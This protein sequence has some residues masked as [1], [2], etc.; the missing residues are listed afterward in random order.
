[1]LEEALDPDR[2]DARP[3]AYG[4]PREVVLQAER[5]YTE[6]EGGEVEDRLRSLGYIE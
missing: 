3:P 1:V 6:A 4:E 5:G 2:L